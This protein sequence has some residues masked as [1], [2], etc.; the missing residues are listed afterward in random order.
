MCQV[1]IAGVVLGCAWP[2]KLPIN[3]EPEMP[4]PTPAYE[5]PDVVDV[6]AFELRSAPKS[7]PGIAR[8]SAGRFY[9]PEG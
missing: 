6:D 7:H 8:N 5:W 2:S 4:A 1:G 3:W 9:C